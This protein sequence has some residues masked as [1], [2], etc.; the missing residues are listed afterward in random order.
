MNKVSDFYSPNNH[1]PLRY[2]TQI[3]GAIFLFSALSCA[4]NLNSESIRPAKEQEIHAIME[5]YGF[6]STEYALRPNPDQTESWTLEEFEA[7]V[8][9][10]RTMKDSAEVIKNRSKALAEEQERK[11]FE[12]A[13]SLTRGTEL[14][15]ALVILR[16]PELFDEEVLRTADSIRRLYQQP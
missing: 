13:D 1:F 4:S 5:S 16:H 15:Q 3:S 11:I 9:F 6:D 10:V 8:K 12:L 14:D 2:F 7:F